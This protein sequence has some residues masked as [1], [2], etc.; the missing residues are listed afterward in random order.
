MEEPEEIKYTPFLDELKS[1]FNWIV[2]CIGVVFIIDLLGSGSL[3]KSI[4]LHQMKFMD[5][6]NKT[7]GFPLYT[8]FGVFS[9]IEAYARR[10]DIVIS[11]IC[12]VL[13]G[14]YFLRGLLRSR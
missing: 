9:S 3:A 4:V 14:F 8:I 6:D 5:V 11:G 7:T 13:A 1:P 12:L 2:L 10:L